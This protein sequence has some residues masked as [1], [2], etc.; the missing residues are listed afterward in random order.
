MCN[1]G[2][3]GYGYGYGLMLWTREFFEECR[4]EC[5]M[6]CVGMWMGL[7]HG[8]LFFIVKSNSI[9][10]RLASSLTIT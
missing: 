9:M 5:V 2:L 3:C 4:G 10:G 1:D 8:G 6:D 7:V